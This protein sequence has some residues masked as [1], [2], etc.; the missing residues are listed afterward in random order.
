MTNSFQLLAEGEVLFAVMAIRYF[1]YVRKSTDSEERQMLSIEAQLAEVRVLAEKEHLQIVA[2]FTESMTA[3]MPGR[4]IFNQMIARVERGD[5]QGILSWHPDRLARNSI[6]GGRIVYLLDCGKLTSLKFPTFWFENTPQGKFMMSLAFG[7]SKLYV[8]SL[9][10]NVR[11]GIRQKLRRGEWPGWAPIGYLNDKTS[12]KIVVDPIEGPRV[13][14]LFETYASGRV[15]LNDLR[16]QAHEWGMKSRTGKPLHRSHIHVMLSNAFYFGLLK[17]AGEVYQGTHEPMV[18]K[19]LFDQVQSVLH[20]LG[21]THFSRKHHFPFLGL[22]KCVTCDGGITAER[23][24][25][26]HYYRCSRKRGRCT[27]PYLREESFADQIQR[28]IAAVAL[29]DDTFQKM[30]AALAKEQEASSQPIEKLKAETRETVGDISKKLDRLLD[31]H[32][33]ETIEKAE[34]L[35]KKELL[36]NEKLRLEERLRKLEQT[37]MG[38][39]EPTKNFL[40]AAHRAGAIATS[41]DMAER[42]EFLKKIGSN[43]RLGAKRL[44]FDYEKPWVIL[45]RAEKNANWSG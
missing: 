25:G 9:S 18:S 36:L 6:D 16:D 2:E 4:P 12:R 41:D 42:K 22:A 24:R 5:A 17:H 13:R 8:D 29:P 20:R 33:D 37:R 39:L 27:E 19:D 35:S 28:A 38:W 21:R 26:H 1:L 44:R 45:A 34:Y 43:V 30:L 23:Q 3:K 14:R 31:A 11:R 32:L 15:R 7:Q 40:I 10:E